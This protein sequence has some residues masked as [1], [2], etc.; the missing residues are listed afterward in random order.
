[1]YR[2][3]GTSYQ[4]TTSLPLMSSFSVDMPVQAMTEEAMQTVRAEL[5][6]IIKDNIPWIV[7]AMLGAAF[8]GGAL[9][10]WIVPGSR[11]A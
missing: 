5:D 11:R 6:D 1:M 2:G 3:L 4:F 7:G 10:N 8:V 9:A